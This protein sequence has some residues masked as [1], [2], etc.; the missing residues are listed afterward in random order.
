MG[1]I[2]ELL[3]DKMHE[4][5]LSEEQENK[6]MNLV[7]DAIPSAFTSLEHQIDWAIEQVKNQSPSIAELKQTIHDNN[8]AYQIKLVELEVKNYKLRQALK[9]VIDFE[10][11]AWTEAK[12]L[13]EELDK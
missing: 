11:N 12:K 1:K 7:A 10:W 4:A 3:Y 2:K 9:A 8:N 13:L 6:V 5:G